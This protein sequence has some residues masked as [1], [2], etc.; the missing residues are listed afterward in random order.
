MFSFFLGVCLLSNSIAQ[1]SSY[2]FWPEVDVWYRIN[3]SWRASSF[4]AI[5]KYFESKSRDLTSTFLLDYAFG[6]TKNPF[7]VRLQDADRAQKMKAWLLR[8]GYMNGL[9]LSDFGESYSEDMAITEIHKRI[10]LL[11]DELLSVR[12]R[13]DLRWIGQPANF[14]YRFRL[15]AMLEK[16]YR[17]GLTSVIPFVSIE[18][19]W[20]S[21]YMKVNRNR[22]IVGATLAGD[23]SLALEGNILYQYDSEM[24]KNNVYVFNL[25]LHI[26][27]DRLNEKSKN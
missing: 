22:T 15:R 25:I 6:K 19:F 13:N 7:F 17:F 11:G 4:I 24:A 21:R 3:P 18:P 2:E 8:G 16:E 14:S 10:P 27:F 26:Y 12:A 9:S 20:D 1:N 5:T 23:N